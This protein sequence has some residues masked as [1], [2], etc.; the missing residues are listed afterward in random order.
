MTAWIDRRLRQASGHLDSPL[1]G[2]SVIL[3]G[4]FGQLPPVGDRPLFANLTTH[5]LSVHGYQVYQT[6]DTVV[7]LEQVL[8][9]RGSDPN[10][11]R[12]RELLLRLRN[13][14]VTEDMFLSRD[15]SKVGNCDDFSDA[16]RLFCDK[17]SVAQYNFE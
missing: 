7:L 15:P 2:F 16:I 8:R 12:F 17:A 6:F 11:M 9:Q 1:G 14:N 3:V 13:G 4:D 10:A 5:E